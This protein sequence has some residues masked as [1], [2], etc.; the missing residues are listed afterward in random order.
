[1]CCLILMRIQTL[2][3]SIYYAMAFANSVLLSLGWLDITK[4]I[5]LNT[6]THNR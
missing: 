3:T 6:L 2:A 1:M 4:D 5:P